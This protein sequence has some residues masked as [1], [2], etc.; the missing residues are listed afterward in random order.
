MDSKQIGKDAGVVWQVLDAS[1]NRS[2][3]YEELKLRCG[4]SENALNRAL[5]WLAREDKLEFDDTQH[6][7]SLPHFS[8]FSFF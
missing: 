4:L 8:F 3:T 1:K 5:G 7:I 6:L 2:C